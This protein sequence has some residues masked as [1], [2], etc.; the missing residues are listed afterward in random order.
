MAR[1]WRTV[2]VAVGLW[3]GS[4]PAWAGVARAADDDLHWQEMVGLIQPGNLVGAGTGQVA[5]GGQPWSTLGG[6]AKVDLRT[7][8]VRFRVAG[9]VL[10][11]GNA[12]GTPGPIVQVK[13]TLVCDAD[14][15]ASGGN[16]VLI[17]TPLVPL[18]AQ[19]NAEFQGDLGSLPAVCGTE[20][21]VAFLVR[22]AAGRWIANGAVL[23]R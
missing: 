3:I 8:R 9:L 12:I 17:D 21:D 16:S 23:R 7:G 13:G 14:G 18:D 22:I 6:S 19:G 4:M 20:P 11:G 2:A 15:S 10:A 1:R 5:G